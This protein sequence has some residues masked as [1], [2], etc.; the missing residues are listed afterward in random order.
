MQFVSDV[1]FTDLDFFV[2]N[3]TFQNVDKA[4]DR[5]VGDSLPNCVKN[6]LC[7]YPKKG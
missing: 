7:N 3:Q 5:E 6:V 4:K 2:G 1:H